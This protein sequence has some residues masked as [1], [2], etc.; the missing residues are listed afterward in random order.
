MTSRLRNDLIAILIVIA[1]L[2]L[3][4]LLSGCMTKYEIHKHPDGSVDVLVQSFREFDQ[5]QVHY[6]RGPG[7][8]ATF[9]F[10]AAAATT[11]VSPLEQAAATLILQLP[12]LL[13]QPPAQLEADE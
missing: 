5:P 3:M 8:E 1:A 7:N 10:G 6:Q 12:A 9:D 2:A 13:A 11:A 4:L